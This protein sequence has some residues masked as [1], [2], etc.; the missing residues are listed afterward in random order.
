MCIA[1][2]VFHQGHPQQ[3]EY[4]ETAFATRIHHYY[5]MCGDHL[6]A[7]VKCYSDG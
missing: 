1:P 2:M 7:V 4:E 6:D 5:G 3:Q